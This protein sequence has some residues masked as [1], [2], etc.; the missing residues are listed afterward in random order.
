MKTDL[1]IEKVMGV[2]L[3]QDDLE[4]INKYRKIRLGRS[5]PWEHIKNN[6]FHDR[7]FFL[8][9]DAN[10]LVSFGT[11]RPIKIYIDTKEVEIMGIQ[12]II[13]VVQGKG[14]GKFLMQQM[15]KHA[16][17]DILTLV[18]FCEHKNA[19]FYLKSGLEVFK[20]KNLNFVFVQDNGEEY[21]EEGDVI[22]YSAEDTIVK[23]S[24]LDNKKIIHYVPHW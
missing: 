2:E 16:E 3:E 15:I 11:L 21:T 20:D 24:I 13:S 12:A 9:R 18:G 10:K 14:Y 7:L 22:F 6:H 17:T 23:D 19:E 1:K 5:K 4:I 8:V